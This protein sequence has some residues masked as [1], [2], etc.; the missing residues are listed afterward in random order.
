MLP[1]DKRRL[2]WITITL[3]IGAAWVILRADDLTL[4]VDETWTIF[5]TQGTV[6]QMLLDPDVTWPPGHY[7]FNLLLAADRH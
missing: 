3:L 1:F 4:W 5:Q 2:W 6:E 7:F